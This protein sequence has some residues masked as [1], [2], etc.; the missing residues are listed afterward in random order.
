[1]SSKVYVKE[2]LVVENSIEGDVIFEEG[3]IIKVKFNGNTLIG[4][5]YCFDENYLTLE[6][7]DGVIDY[8][9]IKIADIDLIEK[10]V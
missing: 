2:T 3:I 6:D 7:I 1:M 8:V 9:E 4:T 10:V 5:L